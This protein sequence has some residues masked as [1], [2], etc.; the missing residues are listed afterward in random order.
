MP[1]EIGTSI[2]PYKYFHERNEIPQSISPEI[3]QHDERKSE[4]Y[5]TK[6]YIISKK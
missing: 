6:K 2:G 4:R 5:K 1:D 3:Y